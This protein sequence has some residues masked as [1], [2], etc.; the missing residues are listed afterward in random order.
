MA[1]LHGP[2]LFAPGRIAALASISALWAIVV[3]ADDK[4]TASPKPGAVSENSKAVS[5]HASVLPIL[6]ANC[7][8]CHQ[9]A[10]ASGKLDLTIYKSILTVG[11][12]GSSAVVPG[13]PDD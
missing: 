9:P 7:Q 13:K 1:F 11:D 8:G 5:Y 12:S 4:P 6:Q 3:V 2:R 10:K